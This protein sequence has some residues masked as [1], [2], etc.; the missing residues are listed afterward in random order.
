MD[1]RP[2]IEWRPI[3]GFEGYYEVSENGDVR[4]IDRVVPATVDSMGR[5]I[6]PYLFKGRVLKKRKHRFGYW[7]VTLSKNNIRCSRTVHRLVAEAFIGS[8]KKDEVV[9]HF[10]GNPEDCRACNLAYGTQR[11]NM[12][13][14]IEQDTVEY[15]ERRYNAKLKNEQVLQ[16]KSLLQNGVRNKKIAKEFDVSE[17]LVCNISRGDAWSR[18]GPSLSKPK[19]IKLMTEDDKKKALMLRDEGLTYKEIAKA[20]GVSKNQVWK[21]V[22]GQINENSKDR[23]VE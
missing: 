8:S 15:G 21:F 10:N 22:R 14:A 6:P 7:L 16:I 20:I 3:V 2:S 4:S 23:T 1:M 18:V 13:D 12:Q 17:Q 11:D 5:S 9:R 19:K